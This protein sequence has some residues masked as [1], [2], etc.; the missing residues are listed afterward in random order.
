MPGS[1][2]DKIYQT[3]EELRKAGDTEKAIGLFQQF[4]IL[5]PDHAGAWHRKG[6]CHL[7]LGQVKDDAAQSDAWRAVDKAVQLNPIFREAWLTR[8]IMAARLRMADEA[9]SRCRENVCTSA[10]NGRNPLCSRLFPTQEVKSKEQEPA[11]QRRHEQS[12]KRDFQGIY[13]IE[14]REQFDWDHEH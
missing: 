5:N 4:L 13:N 2:S 11:R 12:R 1:T 3:A 6:L 7:A 10:T 8:A 9:W 14:Y